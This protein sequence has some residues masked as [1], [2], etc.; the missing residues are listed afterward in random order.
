MSTDAPS[1]TAVE[2][3]LLTMTRTMPTRL[4]ND[5]VDPGELTA[6]IPTRS[7]PSDQP[8]H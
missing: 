3:P 7:D 5:S 8:D 2:P 4:R 1:R 6:A